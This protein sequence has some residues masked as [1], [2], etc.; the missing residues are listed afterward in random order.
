MM[1][2]F[3]PRRWGIIAAVLAASF[4]SACANTNLHNAAGTTKGTNVDNAV[5][6][7]FVSFEDLVKGRKLDSEF[8]H[9]FIAVDGLFGVDKNGNYDEGYGQLMTEQVRPMIKTELHKA[10][11]AGI[12]SVSDFHKNSLSVTIA[13]VLHSLGRGVNLRTPTHYINGGAS[14]EV[15]GGGGGE[16]GHDVISGGITSYGFRVCLNIGLARENSEEVSFGQNCVDVATVDTK[17]EFLKLTDAITFVELGKSDQV[18][19]IQA[20]AS[21]VHDTLVETFDKGV[22]ESE[23]GANL[24]S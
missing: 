17:I 13:N 5:V 16:A 18:S 8:E 11:A 24:T 6:N 10:A 3:N 14:V 23:E 19:V 1:K 12:G 21:L 9:A 4:V 15:Y 20:F 2:S 22:F 7:E